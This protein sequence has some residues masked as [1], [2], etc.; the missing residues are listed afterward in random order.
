M[1]FW[2]MQYC[3]NFN[4]LKSGNILFILKDLLSKSK[5]FEIFLCP[6]Q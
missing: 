1:V 2:G 4:S 6:E 3:N 5:Q